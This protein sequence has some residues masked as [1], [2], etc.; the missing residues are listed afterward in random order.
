[1]LHRQLHVL[2][3]AENGTINDCNVNIIVISRLFSIITYHYT[4]TYFR[5]LENK[6]SLIAKKTEN[7]NRKGTDM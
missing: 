2:F 5:N 7:F 4:V 3:L 1:M 6:T